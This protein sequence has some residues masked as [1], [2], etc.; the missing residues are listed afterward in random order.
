MNHETYP[1]SHSAGITTHEMWPF[2][3]IIFDRLTTMC[4]AMGIKLLN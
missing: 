4:G 2:G 3:L 1:K